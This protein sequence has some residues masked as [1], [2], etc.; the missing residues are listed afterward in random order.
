M[1][2]AAEG[3]ETAHFCSMCG[4]QF[5]SMK[6]TQEVREFALR[7]TAQIHPGDS[8]RLNIGATPYCGV[9]RGERRARR[10]EA[11]ELEL[12]PRRGRRVEM[13]AA[14]GAGDGEVG[15]KGAVMRV[16][17]VTS[18]EFSPDWARGDPA[19]G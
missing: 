6:I 19:A 5:C 4:P 2:N 8:S 1:R 15:I 18:I 9:G 12:R 16:N 7:Q 3:A 10:V 17:R 13:E 11:G 14:D